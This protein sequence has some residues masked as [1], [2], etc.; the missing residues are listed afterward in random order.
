MVVVVEEATSMAVV[1]LVASVTAVVELLVSVM[2][3]VGDAVPMTIIEIE[4]TMGVRHSA[5]VMT[6]RL[7]P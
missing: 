1:K 4:V 6:V 3:V 5:L 7:P 2:A